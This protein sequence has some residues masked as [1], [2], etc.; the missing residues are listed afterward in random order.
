MKVYHLETFPS[1][2]ALVACREVASVDRY[3]IFP[4]LTPEILLVASGG[5]QRRSSPTLGWPA[6]RSPGPPYLSLWE[7]L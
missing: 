2:N 3:H 5:I 6:T 1:A 4:W 7:G